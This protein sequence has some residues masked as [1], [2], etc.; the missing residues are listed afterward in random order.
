MIAYGFRVPEA[1]LRE[2]DEF[3]PQL[4]YYAWRSIVSPE[5]IAKSEKKS[6]EKW[7]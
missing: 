1:S 7:G 6:Q 2:W 5:E 4:A 3:E